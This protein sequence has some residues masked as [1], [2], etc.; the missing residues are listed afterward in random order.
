MM[1]VVL[2]PLYRTDSFFSNH[3]C[4][5]RLFCFSSSYDDA[6]GNARSPSG[7]AICDSLSLTHSLTHTLNSHIY[8]DIYLSPSAEAGALAAMQESAKPV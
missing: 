1:I 5:L 6:T 8:V 7:T 2:S 4:D 3:W